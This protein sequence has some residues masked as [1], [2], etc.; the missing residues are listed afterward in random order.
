MPNGWMG[1]WSAMNEALHSEW[2]SGSIASVWWIA[3]ESDP[4]S[5]LVLLCLCIQRQASREW[6]SG[7][8]GHHPG[9]NLAPYPGPQG[10]R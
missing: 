6:R 3:R 2:M 1:G 4:Q 5:T 8:G 7:T 9:R 10:L